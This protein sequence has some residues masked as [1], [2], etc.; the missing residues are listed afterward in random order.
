MHFV[1]H[2]QLVER[3]PALSHLVLAGDGGGLATDVLSGA[4][5]A[6][7]DLRRLRLAVLSSC[8]T[9]QSRSRRDDTEGG[10]AE[11]FLDAGAGAVVSSLWEVD[12]AATAGIMEALHRALAHGAPGAIALREAQLHALR[13]GGPA[14]APRVWSTFRY[15]G[16]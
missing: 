6:R 14:A 15:D 16:G 5:I 9:V 10:L 1:G 7:L 2:A 11:A 13:T 8:G 4:E 12:D 3:V